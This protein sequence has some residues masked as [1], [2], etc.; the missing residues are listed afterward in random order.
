MNITCEGNEGYPL[1][2]V[3][4]LIEA[5]AYDVIKPAFG[6]TPPKSRNCG[7]SAVNGVP[8]YVINA[9]VATLLGNTSVP[10]AT[11]AGTFEGRIAWQI[12]VPTEKGHQLDDP[13]FWC[14]ATNPVADKVGL[15]ALSSSSVITVN[16]MPSM[17]I[18]YMIENF[19]DV[20]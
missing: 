9:E 3:N 18:Y 11:V 16:C 4:L 10:S 6:S 14:E 13:R 17:F 12:A 7:A 5:S 15:S 20:E 2:L 19:F 8:C 1:G